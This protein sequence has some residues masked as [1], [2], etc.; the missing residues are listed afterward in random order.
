MKDFRIR[1]STTP[2]EEQ[3]LNKYL[4]EISREDM[5]SVDEEVRLAQLIKEGN[6]EALQKLTRAHLRFVISVAKQYQHQWLPLSDLINEG[7]LGLIKAAKKFDET[8][9]FK[10]ISYAVWRIRQ[11]IL[12]ALAEQSRIV[13]LPLNKIGAL[14]KTNKIT[15]RLEQQHERDPS[16]IELAE[17]MELPAKT[18][19]NILE[20]NIKPLSLDNPIKDNPDE[21][22][23]IDNIKSDEVTDRWLYEK[24]LSI[25][26]ARVLATL[27]IKEATVTRLY[28]GIEQERCL[29]TEEIAKIFHKTPET[30][31]KFR[32]KTREKIKVVNGK[33]IQEKIKET[34]HI[35]TPKEATIIRLLLW[36]ELRHWLTL[37]EIAEI[38]DLTRERVRQIKEKAIRKLK[39][40]KKSKHLKQF[41]E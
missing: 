16:Y 26:I 41:L 20:H 27:T 7:N 12:Q 23:Y 19:R 29:T 13:R 6:E 34:I 11:G 40:E 35:L 24:S 5:I 15:R 8:R 17:E 36:I 30:I 10:F 32:E 3:S 18:I 2:R 28:F 31:E 14:T 33:T 39:S 1:Y 37:E 21:W 22:T 25:E 9:W 38:L 4:Q